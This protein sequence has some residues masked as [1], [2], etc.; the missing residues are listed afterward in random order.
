MFYTALD[1]TLIPDYD[2]GKN[3]QANQVIR[4]VLSEINAQMSWLQNCRYYVLTDDD[5]NFEHMTDKN[6]RHYAYQNYIDFM[7][8]GN[9]VQ[10]TGPV[11]APSTS[12]QDGCS[13]LRAKVATVTLGCLV[14]EASSLVEELH[15]FVIPFYYHV[16]V[17]LSGHSSPRGEDFSRRVVIPMVW[18]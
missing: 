5:Q 18:E 10:P 4:H 17:L 14:L 15:Q 2:K 1:R 9:V 16:S 13:R 12:D 6:K 3:Q 8:G 7:F 11:P